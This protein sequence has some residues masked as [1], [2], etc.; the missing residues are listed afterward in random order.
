MI[1]TSAGCLFKWMLYLNYES[2]P[3]GCSGQGGGVL[4][5]HHRRPAA[6]PPGGGHAARRRALCSLHG[7]LRGC[8]MDHR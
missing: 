7:A 3:S 2:L 6:G 8:D 4:L 5:P 1:A